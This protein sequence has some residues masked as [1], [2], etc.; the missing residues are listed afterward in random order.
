V[1]NQAAKLDLARALS[2][3]S[4]RA[5]SCDR[6]R[7]PA[8]NQSNPPE[9]AL[10]SQM[11]PR[12]GYTIHLNWGA[13]AQHPCPRQG[14]LQ[15]HGFALVFIGSIPRCY[16]NLDTKCELRPSGTT[17][18]GGAPTQE[19]RV[20]T[21]RY[22]HVTPVLHRHGRKLCRC[23]HRIARRL[24]TVPHAQRPGLHG[25]AEPEPHHR[26]GRVLRRRRADRAYDSEFVN[27]ANA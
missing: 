18:P 20:N 3:R 8:A 23:G 13:G 5:L 10:G 6:S 4:R 22:G 9:T 19:R 24:Q 17:P 21:Q 27:K 12:C 7:R 15:I 25:P 2:D 26:A 16:D 11:D 1:L 14:I